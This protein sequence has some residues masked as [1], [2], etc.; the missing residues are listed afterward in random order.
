LGVRIRLRTVASVVAMDSHLRSPH[1][2]RHM[3]PVA[4]AR[5][6]L[7]DAARDVAHPSTADF[8]HTRAG[9]NQPS[10]RGFEDPLPCPPEIRAWWRRQPDADL[11]QPIRNGVDVDALRSMTARDG[12]C[13]A[14]ALI[15]AVDA[16]HTFVGAL[17]T[18]APP[19]RRPSNA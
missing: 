13:F 11:P 17:A 10:T 9:K 16:D 15:P 7:V 12:T 2:T 18:P 5:E 14:V 3:L 6:S 19:D 8:P 4:S 1:R